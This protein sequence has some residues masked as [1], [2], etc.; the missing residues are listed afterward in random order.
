M[1]RPS[2]R[3]FRF[4]NTPFYPLGS[5]R[6]AE[7][8]KSSVSLSDRVIHEIYKVSTILLPAFLGAY[9]FF[10]ACVGYGKPPVKWYIRLLVGA[11]GLFLMFPGIQQLISK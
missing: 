4:E 3:A 5:L 1:P 8:G 7:G 11:I 9:M 2:R 6:T 10:S